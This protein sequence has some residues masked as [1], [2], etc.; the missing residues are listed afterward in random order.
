MRVEKDTAERLGYEVENEKLGGSI[1][2]VDRV[3][4]DP[5]SCGVTARA[6]DQGIIGWWVQGSVADPCQAALDLAALSLNRAF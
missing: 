3:P 6:S 1:V 4:G 5:S 2:Y